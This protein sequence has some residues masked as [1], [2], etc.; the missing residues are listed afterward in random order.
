MKI[1]LRILNFTQ[2]SNPRI[3]QR[4]DNT[5][6]ERRSQNIRSTLF[7]LENVVNTIKHR[8]WTNIYFTV[9]ISKY[10]FHF[11]VVFC[12]NRHPSYLWEM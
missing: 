6:Q 7:T 3:E 5:V 9:V 11:E 4:T 8:I 1:S 10:F 12:K 2:G